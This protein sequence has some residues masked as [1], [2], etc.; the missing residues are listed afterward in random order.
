MNEIAQLNRRMFVTSGA[1][2]AFGSAFSDIGFAGT[3]K[4]EPQWHQLPTEPYSGKQDDIF[5]IDRHVGWYGNGKG[6]I[7]KTDDGGDNWRKVLDQP[8]TFVRALGF[9]NASVGVMG[10]VGTD[11]FPGVTDDQPIYRTTDGG[12]HWTPVTAIDGPKPKGICAIDV[13]KTPFI[14][15]GVLNSR[16]TIRA[17][18]RVGG[19]AFLMTSHDLGATWTSVDMSAHT[20]M[21][22]DVKFLDERVGFIAGASNA[23]VQQSH[24]IVLKTSDG[25]VTWRRVFETQRLWEITWKLSFPTSRMGYATIQSYNPDKT[26]DWRYVGKSID[27]G[28]TWHEQPLI[29]D[30]AWNELGVCF[31]DES[32]GW[33]G[34][35]PGGLETR[36]GGESW[37]ST[38]LGKAI[39]KFR[40]VRDA[41]GTVV[42][43]IG[44]DV[45][46]LELGK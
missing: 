17:G 25:G 38:T 14:N 15:S 20:S 8:G 11:Y 43:A 32:H 35:M 10:N 44:K 40:V 36:D 6:K 24:A 46:R 21:I 45:F 23:D 4:A 13:L 19:P 42:Y 3:A 9:A 5:F 30:P 26:A 27:G 39:N 1:V 34:G 7:F 33:I 41:A 31:L 22:L 37:S 18:G 2:A 28:D 16:I 12:V 29:R